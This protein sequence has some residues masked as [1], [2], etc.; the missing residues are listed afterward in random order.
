M[1][2]VDER[3]IQVKSSRLWEMCAVEPRTRPSG[4]LHSTWG[5]GHPATRQEMLAAPPFKAPT[6][7]EGVWASGPTGEMRKEVERSVK[8][9]SQQGWDRKYCYR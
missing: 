8:A 9:E 5:W 2:N 4:A 1:I 7:T 3:I 6:A